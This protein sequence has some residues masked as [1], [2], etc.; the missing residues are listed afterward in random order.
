M[1]IPFPETFENFLLDYLKREFYRGT[2][3]AA[4]LDRPFRPE[5]LRFFSKGVAQLSTLFTAERANLQAGYLNQPQL[6]AAYLLYFLPINFAK[7]RGVLQQLPAEFW[8]KQKYRVLDLGCGPASASLAFLEALREK[9]SEAEVELVLVEQNANILK[10]AQN[11]LQ[12]LDPGRRLTIRA[13]P[14]WLHGFRFQGEFDLILM[15]HVLNELVQ[16]GAQERA[17]W[18]GPRLEQHLAPDGIAALLEPALKRPTRE[19]MALRDH[20][21]EGGELAVLAPCLHNEVCPMLAA[22][23]NDWCH[24]Y[25]DWE[26]PEYLQALDRLVKNDNRFLKVAYLLLGRKQAWPFLAKRSRNVFRVVSNRMQTRGKTEAVLCGPPG[27]VTISRLDRERRDSNA[28]LDELRRGDLLKIEGWE[29]KGFEVGRNLRLS[30]KLF[31]K[32]S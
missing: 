30:A 1:L 16:L 23:R 20:V 17:E 21:I 27:R 8:K 9:Q 26:E 15:S 19:L 18:L 31:L 3:R 32:K 10:D 7:T 25:V 22:T 5:D 28:A 6:R 4:F 11:L 29:A 24:F 14:L 13:F 12:A 2:R